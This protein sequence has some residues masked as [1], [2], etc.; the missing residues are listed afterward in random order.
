MLYAQSPND[1]I[2]MLLLQNN[3]N[4]TLKFQCFTLK[5]LMIKYIFLLLQNN[6][7][8]T[9]KFRCFMLEALMIQ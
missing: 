5:A 2:K 4:I 3:I 1:S 6:I 7:N 8:I 9:L